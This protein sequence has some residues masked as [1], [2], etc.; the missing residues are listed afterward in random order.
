MKVE[1][2]MI[3]K[4]VVTE[5]ERLDPI[6][7]YLEDFGPC[8]G[9][10]T[11]TCFNESWT[12]RWGGMGNRTVAEFVKSCDNHYLAKNLSD[13]PCEINDPE[14]L[15]KDMLK[16]ILSMRRAHDVNDG[17]ARKFYDQACLCK[18]IESDEIINEHQ[19]LL[20][21]CY[22]DEW[23]YSI[24]KKPNPDY[25]YLCRIITAVREALKEVV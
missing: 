22:G 21:F 16:K 9:K 1:Q 20:A 8:Q 3:R 5:V 4:L 23:W 25:E 18:H 2:E 12:A 15:C 17:E 19:D 10:I 24:P 13:I 14:H 6:T 11:I 7:I